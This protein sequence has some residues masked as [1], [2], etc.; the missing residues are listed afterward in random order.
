[1]NIA[2]P[3]EREHIT[4]LIAIATTRD[5]I[6]N[7]YIFKGARERNKFPIL[8]EEGAT[9]G[10]QKKKRWMDNHL[11]SQWMDHFLNSE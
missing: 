10:M 1:M 11:F 7:Y 3:N 8:C 5:S 9:M 2:L 4:I 6:F